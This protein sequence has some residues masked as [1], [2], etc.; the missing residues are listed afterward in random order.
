M[1]EYYFVNDLQVDDTLGKASSHAEFHRSPQ[2]DE[3]QCLARPVSSIFRPAIIR[4][5]WT[6]EGKHFAGNAVCCVFHVVS[7]R[8]TRPG[9]EKVV[10]PSES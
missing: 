7:V 6:F 10:P 3:S 4:T 5:I 8:S 1:S 9:T 2:E